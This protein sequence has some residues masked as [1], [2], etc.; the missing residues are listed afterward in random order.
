MK[1][2][3]EEITQVGLAA[4]DTFRKATASEGQLTEQASDVL[5]RA[6]KLDYAL[7][8]EDTRAHEARI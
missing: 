7:D 6:V 5:L 2:D 8:P 3:C 1:P 4:L